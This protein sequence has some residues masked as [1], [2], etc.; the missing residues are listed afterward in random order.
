MFFDRVVE[1][2]FVIIQ[3]NNIFILNVCHPSLM[4]MNNCVF[5]VDR[6]EL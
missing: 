5:K 2:F 1:D 4:I 6:I 3:N